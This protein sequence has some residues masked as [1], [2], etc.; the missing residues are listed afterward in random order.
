M[1]DHPLPQPLRAL[2]DASSFSV[3][4]HTYERI[5][6]SNTLIE[7]ML[8]ACSYFGT[9]FSGYQHNTPQQD[10]AWRKVPPLLDIT[11]LRA[12]DRILSFKR[13]TTC[14]SNNHRWSSVQPSKARQSVAFRSTSRALWKL[15]VEDSREGRATSWREGEQ[16]Y[17]RMGTGG[18]D[19]YRAEG[20]WSASPYSFLLQLLLFVTSAMLYL[21]KLLSSSSGLVAVC[22]DSHAMDPL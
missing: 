21:I 20:I 7:T 2:S 15:H 4:H 5:P 10:P 8:H 9:Q 14:S 3:Q 11:A 13:S 6:L 18:L 22:T 19:G 16:D 1:S 17:R 12:T